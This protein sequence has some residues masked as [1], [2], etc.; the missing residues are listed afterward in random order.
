MTIRPATPDDVPLILRFIRELAEYERLA[1]EVVATEDGLR[2]TLFGPRPYAEVV[3]AE[4]A[5][6]PAGFA[7]FFH[8]YSTFLGRPGIYLEDLYVRPEARGK[9]IG[10]ALLAHL[11]RLAVARGCGRLE[12]WVLDW[13]ESAIRFY[14]AL[15]AQAMDDWTVFRVTG[16]ALARLAN[17]SEGR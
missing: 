14:R 3:I 2:D 7:L 10:R 8:N 15:G 1:H 9:G 4:E 12:W 5:G 16:E 17:G 6:E 13:N 11:A